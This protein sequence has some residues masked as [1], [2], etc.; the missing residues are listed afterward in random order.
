MRTARL[1]GNCSAIAA[2]LVGLGGMLTPA[3]A[4]ISPSFP[5]SVLDGLRI[6]SPPRDFFDRGRES[7]EDEVRL[8]QQGGIFSDDVLTIDE[9]LEL[10]QW[11]YPLEELEEWLDAEI[12]II[13]PT[14]RVW[15]PGE[16]SQINIS[17]LVETQTQSLQQDL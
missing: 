12:Y 15:L 8:L 10:E 9:S 7:F 2:V 4:Q 5:N 14:E 17:S 3:I 1:L 11:L 13:S 6:I 16:T